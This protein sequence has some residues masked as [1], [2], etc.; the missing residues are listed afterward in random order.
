LIDESSRLIDELHRKIG[1]NLL[2]F[3]QIEVGLKLILPYIHPD[4][5]A[6]GIEG[7][8]KFQ[9]LV[10]TKTLGM[11]VTEFGH[12]IDVTPGNIFEQLRMNVA[13]RNQLVHH[14]FELPGVTLSSSSG[15][16]NAID[17][18]DAQF[19]EADYFLHLVQSIT[20]A[21]LTVLLHTSS[22][23]NAEFKRLYQEIIQ[24]LPLKVDFIKE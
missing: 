8:L 4:G 18:V 14:F 3:Q 23:D 22:E 19:Q 24:V 7:L 9:E 16:R 12:S 10:A 2:R 15:I 6:H 1:R 13:A 20:V 17:Y 5:S 21:L 11:L